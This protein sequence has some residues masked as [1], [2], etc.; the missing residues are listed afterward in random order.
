MKGAD[1]ESKVLGLV[2]KPMLVRERRLKNNNQLLY[3]IFSYFLI[4]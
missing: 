1:A 4:K 2:V 3:V